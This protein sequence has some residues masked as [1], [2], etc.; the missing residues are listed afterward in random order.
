ML[1][2]LQSH[3]P[4]IPLKSAINLKFGSFLKDEVTNPRVRPGFLRKNPAIRDLSERTLKL[5]SPSEKEYSPSPLNMYEGFPW[6][7]KYRNSNQ[8]G[9]KEN[10]L[11]DPR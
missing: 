7:A 2:F 5:L 10:L 11:V 9:V 6:K 4:N 1:L 8:K 3:T